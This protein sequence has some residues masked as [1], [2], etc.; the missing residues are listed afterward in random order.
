[1]FNPP[2]SPTNGAEYT[3]G[4]V[5]W[6][7][8]NPPGV[9]NIKD[10]TLVGTD[11]VGVSGF[12]IDSPNLKFYYVYADGATSTEQNLGRVVGADAAV[13]LTFI[14]SNNTKFSV[15]NGEAIII[16][17]AA[18]TISSSVAGN[19]IRIDA[20]VATTGL[21][22]VAYYNPSR[23]T[24]GT[25]GQVNPKFITIEGSTSQPGGD[26][27]SF[28]FFAM[29][30]TLTITASNGIATL[31]YL[32]SA[33]IP[34]G[35]ED[36][37]QIPSTPDEPGT[38]VPNAIAII[39]RNATYNSKGVASFL[40]ADFNVT[41]GQVSLTAGTV[42]SIAGKTG[43]VAIRDVLPMVTSST[44]GVAYFNPTYF[45]VAG[46]QVSLSGN[47]AIETDKVFDDGQAIK[48]YNI[49][50]TV[51]KYVSARNAT[52]SLTGV[53]AFN[54][55]YFTV[56]DGVVSLS[57]NYQTGVGTTGDTVTGPNAAVKITK[58]N[59]VA[60]IDAR[61]ATH[62]VTGVASFTDYFF[63]NTNGL[64]GLSGDYQYPLVGGK[65]G[66]TV[67]GTG[68]VS[69]SR[70]NNVATVDARL[71]DN[72][73]TGVASFQQ[74]D[75]Y[76]TPGQGVVGL[77]GTST[78]LVVRDA[79]GV[80]TG[81]RTAGPI[82]DILTITAGFGI[83]AMWDGAKAGVV[84]S[85]ITANIN[86]DDGNVDIL[87]KINGS[88]SLNIFGDSNAISTSASKGGDPH[89]LTIE[90][91]NAGYGNQVGVAGFAASNFSVSAGVVS[92]SGS[93]GTIG[94][95]GIGFGSNDAGLVGKV[96]I[97]AGSNITITQNNNLIT[98]N[99]SASSNGAGLP[100]GLTAQANRLV[101]TNQ[102][103]GQGL[104]HDPDLLFDGVALTFG[105][106]TRVNQGVYNKQREKTFI[107]TNT[108]EE[109]T[110]YEVNPADGPIQY[111]RVKSNGMK[112]KALN[113]GWSTVQ[114][115]T[116]SIMVFVQVLNGKTG[117]FDN[118]VIIKPRPILFGIT[119]GIDQLSIVRISLGANGGLTM[120]F[121]Y[122]SGITGA[123]YPNPT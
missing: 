103:Q 27:R 91:R 84:I 114:G 65:T 21:S 117:S 82:K 118:S 68:A 1:M 99:S 123:G 60:T 110:E 44:T 94:V 121:R 52:H 3:Y 86:T 112:I 12:R 59:N 98:V 72:S 15:A 8:S 119:G 89:T 54:D 74:G 69:V 26:F 6:E 35:S 63:T 48:I 38:F 49:P 14:A 116:E 5:T 97:T 25:D 45:S 34:A 2:A 71:A 19:Q 64:I 22:G 92:L 56:S 100:Q 30:E 16:T 90:A 115:E 39:G 55:T 108:S 20:R 95:T 120:G 113:T 78:T 18:G 88:P 41:G 46:G 47:Y 77:T 36:P 33:G 10:G 50:G 4:N 80:T 79:R 51:L 122:A 62:Q 83:E 31:P 109:L 102:V 61:V 96:N 40:G 9:W 76:I 17:G 87:P 70:T 101:Y 104:T 13:G 43:N 67:V 106:S 75:F 107:F 29:G 57:G 42:R 7:Y 73:V 85:G 66:D 24:V 111:I 28:P 32:K 11:G 105:T 23:F 53:A 93:Y 58:N 37:T 81:H